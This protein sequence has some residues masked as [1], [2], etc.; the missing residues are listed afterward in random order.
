MDFDLN[1]PIGKNEGN[2]FNSLINLLNDL[3][4]MVGDIPNRMKFFF[5]KT[6]IMRRLFVIILTVKLDE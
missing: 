3:L 1:D 5:S 2:E 6:L 4:L